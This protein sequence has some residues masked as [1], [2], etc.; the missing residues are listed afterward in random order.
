MAPWLAPKNSSKTPSAPSPKLRNLRSPTHRGPERCPPAWNP[1]PCLWGRT[2]AP[3][4]CRATPQPT[5]SHQPSTT[6]TFFEPEMGWIWLDN[7]SIPKIWSKFGFASDRL[8]PPDH[9]RHL[10]TQRDLL[11]AKQPWVLIYQFLR[12]IYY[13]IC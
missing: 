8:R 9:Q 3:E 13:H 12:T 5:P 4:I 10:C 1:Y 11:L 6:S 7:P 2:Q